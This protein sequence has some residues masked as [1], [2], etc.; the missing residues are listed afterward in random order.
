M[1]PLVLLVL[2]ICTV[3][4]MNLKLVSKRN[5]VD[6]C[7]DW[8]VDLKTYMALAGEPVRV[9]CALFYSY[10]RTN[11][12]M[13]QSTGLRLMWY[14]NKGDLE[15]PIIFSEVRMSK[16]EDSIWFHSVELQ[17]SG[18]YTCVL[19][20]STYCMKVSMSLTVAENESGLCYNSKIRYLEKSE[21]TKRKTISCPDIEDYRT[22]GQEPDVVWYKECKPKMWR[23]VVI[24]KGNTLL[25]QEVQEE[26]GGNYTCELKFE[27]KLIRRTVE[28]KV[29]ALLTDKP[30]KPLFPMENQPTVIDVQLGNPLTVA[31]KAF[32]G[33]SG[34]S[35]PM[36]YWMK[37]EKF[38]EELEGHIREGEVRLLREHLGEKEVE[39]TLIF[40]AVGEADLANYT[41]HVENRNGRKHASV[42]LRKKDLIYKIELAGGLGAILLLLILLVTIYKCYNIELMLFYRQNFGGDEAADDNKEYDAYLSYTKVDPDALDRDTSE[43]EQFALEILP[44]VLEKHYGY[45]LFIPDRDLIPS[46]TYIEDLTR[47][48][49]QSRRLIIVLTP[50]YVLRRGWSIFEMENRLHNMLVSGEIKVI[51]IECTELKGKVNYHEVES[52]KHTIKLLSV[53]KWKGPKSSKLNSKFWKRLVFEMP[54]KKKEVV[55]RHQVLDSAEQGLFGDLQTVPSI[56]V[57]GTSATLV[58]SRA[59]LTDYHQADSVH[60]RHY[61]RGY[62]YDVSAATLPVASIS[63]HHTYCNIPLTLLNGQLPLNNAVKDPQEFHRN[64]PL[65]PLSA[66][67]LSF[68]SDIW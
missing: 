39:L 32:F 45:K 52:L 23:S 55:S 61:C 53:V 44:D 17:D 66:K 36:I 65:L 48:V 50:D 59:D 11:Y 27:G 4:S 38:I 62:E 19:R 2:V 30:P 6:G 3:V 7:I 28:L 33:F 54:G 12:S 64:N 57:T 21:V 51:L 60:M 25:I 68:T 31:C 49:E 10:I 35:G 22:A 37:G 56:A 34:E 43:E 63:N 14:K 67:E 47:C 9:K 46:G 8:S 42:L 58:E 40:D 15:E 41:C 5:S 29:T 26:D 1:K 24:Q 13:A 20:N 16:D 18:F